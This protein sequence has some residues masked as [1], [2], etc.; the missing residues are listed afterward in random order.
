MPKRIDTAFVE[1]LPDF[2]N[3]D[4][5]VDRGI[6]QAM[7]HVERTV[8]EAVDEVDESFKELEGEVKEVFDDITR[9][10]TAD[11]NQIARTAERA[12]GAAGESFQVA[13]EVAED[14][15]EELDRTASR[16]L[17]QIAVHSAATAQKV[18]G[19]F[20]LM[21]LAGSA[22]LFGIGA[23]AT[24]GLGALTAMGLKS[25]AT[26]EQT[27]I[28]FN[29]LLGSAEEGQRVFKE[30]QKFAAVTPFEFP[31]VAAAAKRFLAF[32]DAVGIADSQLLPFLTTVGDLASVTGAGAEGMN[33]I[34]LALGQISS[35]G[36]TSLEEL[37]QIGEAVPGF[38]PIQAIAQKLG[39]STGEAM[40]MIS[41][42]AVDARTGID[43]LLAGMAK[44]PGAAGAMEKQSQ[45]LLGVFSTFK[46]TIGQALADSFA[47]AIPGIKQALTEIT[48]ILGSALRDLA[49]LLGKALVPIVMVIAQLVD[50]IGPILDPLIEG[51]TGFIQTLQDTGALAHFTVAI[52]AIV[53]ALSPLFPV[54]GQVAAVLADALVPVAEAL[55]PIAGDLAQTLAV[56][57]VAL[58]PLIPPLGELIAATL[59]LIEPWL[60]LIM[61]WD[62]L[63]SNAVLVPIV[64]AL[65][66]AVG[67]LANV[68]GKVADFI[69]HIN[70]KAVRDGLAKAGEA[71]VDFFVMI[72]RFLA[73]V[74]GL[75]RAALHA[76]PRLL[77]TAI[78]RTFDLALEGI[79]IGIGLLITAALKFPGL[80]MQAVTSLSGLLFDFFDSLWDGILKRFDDAMIAIGGFLIGVPGRLANAFNAIGSFLA[81]AWHGIIET[82]K[83]IV[84]EGLKAIGD[85]F[86]HLPE[87]W[88]GFAA[89][90]GGG[91][92]NF[93]KGAI[94]HVISK[95]NEGIA[96]V[97]SK[98]P[99]ID[100][101]RLP[102]LARGGIAMG[103]SIVGEAGAEA[104]IPLTDQRALAMLRD[105]LGTGG[106]TFGPGSVVV[107]VN[108]NVTAQQAN[109]IG[110]QVGRG[111]IGVMS[112]DGIKTAVRVA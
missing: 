4:A 61:L 28:S 21:G 109:V 12:A 112:R 68:I 9:K 84:S 76:M 31:E 37:M 5:A 92:F 96:D 14:A 48:P 7:R 45:T 54:L 93:F 30:L 94:N 97:D 51:V 69:S 11:L 78:E 57:L 63:V 79:G 32:N 47:P 56:L 110:Q 44:F 62:T 86:I 24:A 25:A 64:K 27:Q 39:V 90:V 101:P 106:V 72:G 100:L 58:I 85:F 59:Q 99:G 95:I 107:N 49:P 55:A 29:A 65:A 43:A 73:R 66:V 67:F 77:L 83:T 103:P 26:L 1:F 13:G 80:F 82:G 89:S 34:V 102:L 23:A 40:D 41:A 16:Q 3:F 46:D 19:S 42:G 8:E 15:F 60:K 91:I 111:I 87:R 33:R 108:G 53:K 88:S 81:N 2:S 10:S 70:W 36:K 20:S 38:S 35:K 18:G 98:L 74:P 75:F 22:A 52:G 71:V 104:A 17:N 6:D 50:A 105:A